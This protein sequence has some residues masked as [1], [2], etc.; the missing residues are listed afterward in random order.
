MF[1]APLRPSLANAVGPKRSLADVALMP[2]RELDNA[3]QMFV[4]NCVF[5]VTQPEKAQIARDVANHRH[6]HLRIENTLTD[7]NGDEWGSPSAG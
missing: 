1:K 5:R 2:T 3:I 4:F 7:E 6:R